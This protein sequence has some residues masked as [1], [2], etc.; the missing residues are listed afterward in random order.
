MSRQFMI[1]VAGIT[2]ISATTSASASAQICDGILSWLCQ[3]S[4]SS[5]R[6]P[7]S[8]G[9]QQDK[10]RQ[11]LLTTA[12]AE[13]ERSHK[14]AALAER[15][16]TPQQSDSHSLSSSQHPQRRGGLKL[17]EREALFQQFLEWRKN[18]PV[19]NP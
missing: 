11:R 3:G 1:V 15:R 17:E 18:Q 10:A 12:A 13:P 19:G 4:A 5:N 14:H 9:T 7:A 16:L 2:I 6:E 8:K